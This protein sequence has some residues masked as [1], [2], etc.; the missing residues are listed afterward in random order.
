MRRILSILFLILILAMFL[1]P[2]SAESSTNLVLRMWEKDDPIPGATFEIY[3][4]GAMSESGKLVLSDKFKSYPVDLNAHGEDTSPQAAVLYAYA[5]KDGIAPIDTA[6]TNESGH[7][8]TDSLT[9]GLY[10]I[11]GQPFEYEGYIYQTKP[12]L[13]L[14]PQNDIETGEI[15]KEPILAMKFSSEKKNDTPTSRKVLKTWNDNNSK[16]RPKSLTVHLLKNG[17]IHQTVT[18]TEQNQWRYVWNDLDANAQWQI[19]EDV[20]SG[21]YV[22]VEQEGKTFLLTNTAKTLEPKP[23]E[24]EPTKPGGGKIDQTGMI[25]WPV[26]LLAGCGM[27]F[28]V[29]GIVLCKESAYES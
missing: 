15:L 8:V 18:L 6:V 21:Y 28:I 27:M 24:P 13:I 11:A 7:A 19:V 17:K 22:E 9:D 3:R 16:N 4:V 23:T 14:L 29:I 1:V 26:F 25:L 10:M 5:R 12:Q 2:V 20:P